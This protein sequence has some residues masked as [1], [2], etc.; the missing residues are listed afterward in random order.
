MA[1]ANSQAPCAARPA[2]KAA[3]CAF[4]RWNSRCRSAEYRPCVQRARLLRSR[5][6]GVRGPVLRPPC[7]RHRRFPRTAG[8][9]HGR[10][11]RVRAPHRGAC[12]GSPG[13]LPCLSQPRFISVIRLGDPRPPH[14]VDT[15]CPRRHTPTTFRTTATIAASKRTRPSVEAQSSRTSRSTS[16]S[17]TVPGC[18][19]PGTIGR[20]VHHVGF[21]VTGGD[22]GG[23]QV[24]RRYL[25]ALPERPDPTRGPA[26]PLRGARLA[27]RSATAET[28]PW[29]N[30]L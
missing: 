20:A 15:S 9:R 5:P 13:G 27:I 28:G 11:W 23:K 10:S 16:Q 4:N 3:Y 29:V 19:G 7:I 26:M 25:P 12:D 8:A 2:L 17:M 24:E 21:D 1:A 14:R 22:A 18:C 30:A 6:A